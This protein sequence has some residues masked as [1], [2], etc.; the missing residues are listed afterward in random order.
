MN[1]VNEEREQANC[2]ACVEIRTPERCRASGRGREAVA[3]PS[4]ATARRESKPNLTLSAYV[5]TNVRTS[6]D[7][8]AKQY[9]I[10][11]SPLI[12]ELWIIPQNICF[13]FIF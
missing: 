1:E 2:F 7:K 6:A 4:R 10:L 11:D 13:M 8:S 5:L 3:R 12:S 9:R